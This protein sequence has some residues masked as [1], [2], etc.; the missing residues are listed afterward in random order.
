MHDHTLPFQFL[1]VW[2]RTSNQMIKSSHSELSHH[3]CISVAFV[4]GWEHWMPRPDHLLR[5][6]SP[7]IQS[8]SGNSR[9]VFLFVLLSVRVSPYLCMIV[10]SIFFYFIFSILFLTT[11]LFSFQI[12]P[13]IYLS[14]D[15]FFP[16][17]ILGIH[18]LNSFFLFI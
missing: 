6:S 4:T 11:I 2:T 5:F 8:L 13:L 15:V 10:F 17:Y 16:P 14:L 3:S 18:F 1:N 7:T 12:N 9:S